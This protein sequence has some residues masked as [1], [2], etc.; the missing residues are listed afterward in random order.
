MES[1]LTPEKC[2]FM[3]FSKLI[4]R[5][6]VFKEGK[7]LDPKKVRAIVNRPITTNP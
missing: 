7:I 2:A 5:F 4:L 6:I 1:V 3:V